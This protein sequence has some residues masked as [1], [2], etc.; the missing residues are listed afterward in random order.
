MRSNPIFHIVEENKWYS[1]ET[2]NEYTGDTL[3]RDGFIHCCFKHQVK[4]V[5]QQWFNGVDNLF[6]IEIDP[7]RVDVEIRYENLEGGKEL[8]PHIYGPLNLSAVICVSKINAQVK[9]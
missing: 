3:K 5:L 7:D 9:Y 1:A 4:T 8:F 2:V 6:L